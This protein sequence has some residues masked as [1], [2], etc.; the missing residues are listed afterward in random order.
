MRRGSALVVLVGLLASAWA[1]PLQAQTRTER[2]VIGEQRTFRPGYAIGDLAI[3]N[4]RVCDFRVVSGRREIMLIANGEGYTTL[5]VWDQSSV[6]RDEVAIEVVSREFAKLMDDLVELLRPY[7]DVNIKRLGSRIVLGGTVRSK[8]ELDAVRTIGSAAGNVVSTVTVRSPAA[9]PAE[10]PAAAGTATGG[11]AVAPPPDRPTAVYD[12]T[13][14]PVVRRPVTTA[15][16]PVP[17]GGAAP[18]PVEPLPKQT[19]ANAPVA[20]PAAP[21]PPPPNVAP[22]AS[23]AAM[24]TAPAARSGDVGAP[25]A[26]AAVEYLIEVYESPAAAPPPDVAGPQGARL[27]LGRIRAP[28]GS[29][30]RQY[31]PIGPQSA[32]PPRAIS[33]GLTPLLSGNNVRTLAVIDTNLPVGSY[34]QK[35]N[36]VW[37][38]STADFTVRPGQ[39]RYLSEAELARTVAPTGAPPTSATGSS[40]GARVAGAAA[41]AVA[42]NVPGGSNIPSFGGI[43][44]GGSGSQPKARATTLLIV[45]TPVA[46]GPVT[47]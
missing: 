19:P 29:E 47:R 42:S 2:L 38:R 17:L 25:A 46:A 34:D 11:A 44:G 43:F 4:P 24:P 30:V 6:K 9:A 15:P 12:P 1:A 20:V 14:P 33:I 3:S 18:P 22:A 28:L 21:A 13:P 8:E 27:F 39:T 31:V 7:P 32:T 36:P 10:A 26:T 37:L 40:A 41:D 23:P 35:K 16:E 45:L 5:T